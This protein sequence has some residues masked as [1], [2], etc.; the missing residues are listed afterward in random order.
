MKTDW[1]KAIQELK[2]TEGVRP[3]LKGHLTSAEIGKSIGKSGTV[4]KGII[5]KLLKAGR[6]ESGQM[7]VF[8]KQGKRRHVPTYKLI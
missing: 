7:T 2:A 5:C 4:T 8:D 6:A 3:R 1:L